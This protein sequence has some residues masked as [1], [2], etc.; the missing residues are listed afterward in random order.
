MD[1]VC[2]APPMFKLPLGET[3]RRDCAL[4]CGVS[5]RTAL[6]WGFLVWDW[7]LRMEGR[8]DRHP[9][10][11]LPGRNGGGGL[12]IAALAC[13]DAGT[14]HICRYRGARVSYAA[15]AGEVGWDRGMGVFVQWQPRARQS[16]LNS[17]SRAGMLVM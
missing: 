17:R 1:R 4:I 16:F 8:E 2:V 7:L 14:D 15:E 5:D 12:M 13:S 6:C 9:S 3:M 11:L 10:S